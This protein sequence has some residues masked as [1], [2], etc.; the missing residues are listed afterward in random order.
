M[1]LK[2]KL[3]QFLVVATSITLAVASSHLPYFEAAKNIRWIL[4]LII[5]CFSPLFKGT[6]RF[7]TSVDLFAFLFFSVVFCSYT[8][9]IAPDLTLQRGIGILLCYLSIFFGLWKMGIKIDLIQSVCR[10]LILGCVIVLLSGFILRN[11]GSDVTGRYAGIFSNPNSL[12]LFC[13]FHV[14]IAF[15]TYHQS[16]KWKDL[17]ILL[18][19]LT[20]LAITFSRTSMSGC[21]L[22]I[23]LFYH[24]LSNKKRFWIW[25]FGIV[26][27]ASLLMMDDLSE[28]NE[29]LS[30][31]RP[32]TFKQ[33]GGRVEAW[34]AAR[35][36]ISKKPAMG[37][38]FGTEDKLFERF[39][40]RFTEHAGAYVH[41]AYLG[42]MVQI[43]YVG[44]S[45]F[46]VP[47]YL[48]AFKGF[49]KIKMTISHHRSLL[50]LA[51]YCALV[52]GLWVAM[53]ESWIY[54]AGNAFVFIYWI[55][56]MFFYR[57][58]QSTGTVRKSNHITA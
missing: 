18:F 48:F 54:S 58:Q 13:L 46:F 3:V 39:N 37:Y 7:P 42:M 20:N 51:F 40:Y 15:A 14:P 4:F 29:S 25:T 41:N 6:R 1:L 28:K 27:A 2:V 45:L 21:L 50:P 35:E 34:E 38:G 22:S 17:G 55:Q 24:F 23:I 12:G 30:F 43:G 11:P 10:A 19:I 26:L 8:Y 57:L 5:T 52:I 33:A 44:A 49:F 9:S 32:Q 36:L 56:V 16:R 47:L 53:A 31:L